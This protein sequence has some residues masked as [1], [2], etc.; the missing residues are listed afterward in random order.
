MTVKTAV[1]SFGSGLV[2]TAKILHDTTVQFEI[3]E[4]DSKIN[5]L[6]D[7]MKELRERKAE[8]KNK[9]IAR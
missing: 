2:A 8:L 6:Q 1:R 4:I 5:L 3:D 7:E 9:L